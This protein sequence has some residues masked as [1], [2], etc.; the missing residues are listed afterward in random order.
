MGLE[1]SPFYDP[2]ILDML[3]VFEQEAIR[4]FLGMSSTNSQNVIT[5]PAP[6]SR[7]LRCAFRHYGNEIRAPPRDTVLDLAVSE[8]EVIAFFR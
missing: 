4:R 7:A 8:L 1:V 5:A 2:L 3:Y 6:T